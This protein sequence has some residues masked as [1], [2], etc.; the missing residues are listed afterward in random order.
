VLR[1]C[2]GQRAADR[3][4]SDRRHLRA[5][6]DQ[7][8]LYRSRRD[9]LRERRRPAWQFGSPASAHLSLRSDAFLATGVLLGRAEPGD[10]EDV[11]AVRMPLVRTSPARGPARSSRAEPR[12]RSRS[13]CHISRCNFLPQA[14]RGCCFR[15]RGRAQSGPRRTSARSRRSGGA[16]SGKRDPVVLGMK[17]IPSPKPPGKRGV[18]EGFR[19]ARPPGNPLVMRVRERRASES[20]PGGRR[21]EPG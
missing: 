21:F 13:R 7:G 10:D 14:S 6:A 4:D 17:R 12:S 9:Q 1:L 11:V 16:G 5:L 3:R 18:S 19:A 15:Q 8:R 2:G 20:H